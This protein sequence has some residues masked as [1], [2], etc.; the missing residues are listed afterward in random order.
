[1]QAQ[2]SHPGQDD[3]QYYQQQQQ[4]Q[5][6]QQQQ[7]EQPFQEQDQ[8]QLYYAQQV[9]LMMIGQEGSHDGA[10]D[11][12]E[13]EVSSDS[14]YN[15]AEDESAIAASSNPRLPPPPAVGGFDPQHQQQQQEQQYDDQQYYDQEQQQQQ[16]QQ[17][18]Q[19]HP[20]Q[21]HSDQPL[22]ET[23]QEDF[24]AFLSGDPNQQWNEE[25]EGYYEAATP[26]GIVENAQQQQVPQQQNVGQADEPMPAHAKRLRFRISTTGQEFNHFYTDATTIDDLLNYASRKCGWPIE[27]IALKL[28]TLELK[29]RHLKYLQDNDVL[30]ILPV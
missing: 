6:H 23:M 19:Q 17:H 22:T 8:E 16:Q 7:D 13:P 26:A 18:H 21:P 5:Q 2:V 11:G 3:Q 29:A 14:H 4:Q 24:N 15:P 28:E 9:Q 30:D 27:H 12:F 25:A 20:N 1:V 10:V